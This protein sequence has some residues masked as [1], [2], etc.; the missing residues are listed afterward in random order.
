MPEAG[1]S[2]HE[3][4]ERVTKRY[5]QIPL[6]RVDVRGV[7]VLSVDLRAETGAFGTPNASGVVRAP[8]SFVLSVFA[9][10]QG[11]PPVAE[12]LIWWQ[13][14]AVAVV[15]HLTGREGI[16]EVTPDHLLAAI[17]EAPYADAL[18]KFLAG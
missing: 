6:T 5:G 11:E 7:D 18:R 3:R 14:R 9:P 1:E 2:S 12:V 8:H 13:G 10:T 16:R 15:G 4:V 17:G